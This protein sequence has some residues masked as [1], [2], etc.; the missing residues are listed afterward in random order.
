MVI[1]EI[2][3]YSKFQFANGRMCF[4]PCNASIGTD[5]IF[6]LLAF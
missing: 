4:G 1:E 2:R 6:F 3:N 5:L